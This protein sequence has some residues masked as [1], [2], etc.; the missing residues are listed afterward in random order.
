MGLIKDQNSSYDA[1]EGIDDCMD[2]LSL[3][4][5]HREDSNDDCI[6]N[7]KDAFLECIEIRKI[8]YGPNHPKTKEVE[9]ELAEL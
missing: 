6:Q 2:R 9:D 3:V 7:A 4:D 5:D 1:D 8:V